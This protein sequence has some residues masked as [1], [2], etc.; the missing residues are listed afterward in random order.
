MLINYQS[1]I[2]LDL[3]RVSAIVIITIRLL[4]FFRLHFHHVALFFLFQRFLPFLLQVILTFHLITNP[5]VPLNLSP[6]IAV[7]LLLLQIKLQIL[8]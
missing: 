4:L 7:V 8:I 1:S 3:V 2:L 5:V 6:R